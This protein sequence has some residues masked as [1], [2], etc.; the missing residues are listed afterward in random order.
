MIKVLRVSETADDHLGC[1][2]N[3]SIED[4]VCRKHCVLRLR[5]VVEQDQHSRTELLEDLFSTEGFSERIQ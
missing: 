4:G 2:G 3:F 5:C 1:F